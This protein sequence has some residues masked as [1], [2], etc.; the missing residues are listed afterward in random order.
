MSESNSSIYWLALVAVVALMAFYGHERGLH[1]AYEDFQ[2]SDQK[3]R[4]MEEQRDG[5]ERHEAELNKRLSGLA[6]D[7]IEMEAS[8]RKTKGHVREGETIYQ[9]ILPDES[10]P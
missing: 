1:I 8:V 9:V 10:S 4:S 7:P 2:A 3:V 6:D 5:L